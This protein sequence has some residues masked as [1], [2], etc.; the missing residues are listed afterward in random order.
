MATT[1]ELKDKLNKG[2]EIKNTLPTT[3]SGMNSMQMEGLIEKYKPLIAQVL[4]QH[5]KAEKIIG[6]AI[7]A[8]TKNPKLKECTVTSIIGGVITSSILGLEVNTPLQH[9]YLIPYQN[10]FTK[11]LEAEFQLGYKG[12]TELAY[13]NPSVQDINFKEVRENDEFDYEEGLYPSL[14]HKP[15]KSNRGEI[16]HAYAIVRLKNGGMVYEVMNRDE[17]EEVR[18]RSKSSG[19]DS[20]PW[21]NK[22]EGDYAKM[23]RKTVLRSLFNSGRVPY[24][25]ES[26]YIP[27]DGQTVE[28]DAFA[29]DQTGKYDFSPAEPAVS[30]VIPDEVIPEPV[31]TETP[32]PAKSEPIPPSPAPE[33]AKEDLPE[34]FVAD[35]KKVYLKQI[36]AEANK[37]KKAKEKMTVILN[38]AKLS[39]IVELEALHEDHLSKILQELQMINAEAQR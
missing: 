27:L 14:R 6:L 29:K 25:I 34:D 37:T 9:C 1:G 20:S 10:K 35:V 23:A 21:S 16:T 18:M 31:K 32:E 38:D 4:P 36:H 13:R 33:P 15:A 24:S 2:K 22:F 11:K 12:M 39:R 3:L 30:E 8:L 5:L 19:S 7:N 26:R 17:I 28:L